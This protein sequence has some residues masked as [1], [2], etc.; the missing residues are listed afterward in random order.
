MRKK[1]VFRIRKDS[2]SN[3]YVLES[4]VLGI[5]VKCSIH[6]TWQEARNVA[7]EC[8]KQKGVKYIKLTIVNLK[9]ADLTNG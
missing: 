4:R 7:Y 9:I 5:Y 6:K 2:E 3:R 1:K 8:S